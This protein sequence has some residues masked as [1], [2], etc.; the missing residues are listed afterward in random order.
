MA[1]YI[2]FSTQNVNQTQF[3]SDFG[4]TIGLKSTAQLYKIGKKFRLTDE[5]L[6]IR[7]F[8]NAFN[9]K[10]GEKVGQPG[11]GSA[12]WNY[13]FDPNINEVVELIKE[14]VRRIAAQDPRLE[15]S[16]LSAYSK[17]HGIL[18]EAEVLIAPFNNPI[19]LALFINTL[20]GN[21]S[22]YFAQ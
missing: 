5:Q 19:N 17:E 11:Y 8:I 13:V 16:A 7:D 14:E 21:V 1:T 20:E 12:I 10:Q 9:I 15:L 22:Q 4:A 6:V 18:I 2:G 3:P